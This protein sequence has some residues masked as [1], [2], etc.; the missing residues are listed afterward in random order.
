MLLLVMEVL[1][2]LV[3]Q[4]PRNTDSLVFIKSCR[5]FTINSVIVLEASNGRWHDVYLLW[6]YWEDLEGWPSTHNS[7]HLDPE[8]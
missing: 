8:H 2:D 6:L 3:Y 4:S 5:V 7:R 1:H